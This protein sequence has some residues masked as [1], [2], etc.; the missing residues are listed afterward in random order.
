MFFKK[1]DVDNSNTI[2]VREFTH[3]IGQLDPTLTRNEIK[4]LFDTMDKDR[5]RTISNIEMESSLGITL[6]DEVD[7]KVKSLSWA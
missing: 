1:I 2:S 4:A 3:F 7:E 5:S 6:R